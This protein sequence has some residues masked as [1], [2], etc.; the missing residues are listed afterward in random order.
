MEKE[1]IQ[2]RL[3]SELKEQ[4][5]DL[6]RTPHRD[7][8]IKHIRGGRE[9]IFKY[10]DTYTALVQAAG[11]DPVRP[12]SKIKINREELFGRD[13]QE[14][15]TSHEPRPRQ[16]ITDFKP[17]LAI[18][19]T[20]FP[21]AHKPTL[22]KVYRFAEKAQ[23][24]FIV[25][26]GD[27]MDQW[28]HGRFPSS[29]NFYKP[30]EEM[31]LARMMAT[32]FWLELKKACPK[33]HCYQ[34][35]GNHDLRALKA[36]LQNAPTLEGLVSASIEKLYEFEGVKTIHDYR[37][38]LILQDIMFHHGYMTRHGQQRDFVMQ[39]LVSGHT[40]RGTVLYRALKDR[41]I[42]HLDCG[43]VGDPESK[44][45]TYTPQK[46]TGWTLGWGFIDEHG[47]RFIPG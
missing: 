38:E 18:G 5:I 23:P 29:R 20:H 19:D 7:E 6:G 17:I 24:E 30:D 39:N 2:H 22:E 40:H 28:S 46:T 45:L 8:F 13:I 37:E 33:A 21:F 11:L 44:A 15:I 47:P 43:F 4:A 16:V 35:M 1:A 31:E 36:V 10:F 42:W 26:V 41:T 14:I 34:I 9:L 27:L 25:Q 12:K 32:E 3:I